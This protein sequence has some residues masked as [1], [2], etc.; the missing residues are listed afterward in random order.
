MAADPVLARAVGI[1]DLTVLRHLG[2]AFGE[3]TKI[4]STYRAYAE[5]A[6]EEGFHGIASVFRAIG[7][8]EQ[9]HATNHA[10]VLR[11]MSGPT[12][13]EIPMPHI[14]GS[15]EN[16]RSALVDQRFEV[17]YLYPTF[18]TAA[19]PLVDSTAIRT[20][21]WAL[22]ADKSHVRLLW[23]LIPRVGAD[24]AG[25]AYTPHNFFVCALCGYAAQETESD[26]CPSCNYLWER[27]ETI[28]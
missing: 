17:D 7:R 14:E 16:L 27:F 6:D 5:R 13:V 11:H 8:G 2:T 12:G 20:F 3:E 23:Q 21:H 1:E 24:K 19:V 28:H 26:N 25:W 18:L 22:E 9:I 4:C 10:R 15:L